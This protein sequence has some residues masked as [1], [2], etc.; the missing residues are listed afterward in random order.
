MVIKDVII[1]LKSTG[2]APEDLAILQ[3]CLT[4]SKKFALHDGTT[5]DIVS[6]DPKTLTIYQNGALCKYETLQQ[7]VNVLKLVLF[8]LNKVY[9]PPKGINGK[10][11]KRIC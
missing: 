4:K 1:N 9:V 5:K 6:V 2:I 7:M 11:Q 10:K 3:R 8:A